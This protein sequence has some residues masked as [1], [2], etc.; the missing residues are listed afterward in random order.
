MARVK[1][2]I[3]ARKR[4]KKY[5]KLAKGYV[6][7]RGKLYRTARETVERAGVFAYRDRR[8]KKREFRSLWITRISAAAKA[9][10]ISYSRLMG[11]L[12][13]QGVELDRKALADL[14]ANKPEAFARLVEQVKA[15]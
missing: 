14:A 4:H 12:R 5:L 7:G 6:G 2:G 13:D 1:G 9:A 10:G 15:A 3:K 11:G 8:R